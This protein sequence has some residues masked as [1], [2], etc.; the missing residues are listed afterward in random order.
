[1]S[2]NSGQFHGSAWID[3]PRGDNRVVRDGA[4]YYT[5]NFLGCAGRYSKAPTTT[6]DYSKGIR[7][8][9]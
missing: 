3:S 9:K 1:M 5:S 2:T 8:A 4:Y 7:C 6:G